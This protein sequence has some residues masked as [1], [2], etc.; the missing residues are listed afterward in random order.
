MD[1]EHRILN[2]SY[3]VRDRNIVPI[4]CK[5]LESNFKAPPMYDYPSLRVEPDINDAIKVEKT[6]TAPT[7]PKQSMAIIVYAH[8]YPR[9]NF[10][11]ALRKIN[12]FKVHS[13]VN[14]HNFDEHLRKAH[15]ILENR[16]LHY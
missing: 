13:V 14:K 12:R 3:C 5:S 6:L 2:W 15:L 10:Y 7:F 11:A 8:V 9:L 1:I 4:S 16:L